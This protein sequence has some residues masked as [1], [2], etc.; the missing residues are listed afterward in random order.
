MNKIC[1]I[2]LLTFIVMMFSTVALAQDNPYAEISTSR[3]DDGAFVLGNPEAPVKLIEFS[4]FLCPHCQDY[5]ATIDYFIENYVAT[6]QAQFEYRMYPIV[7]ANL[8]P[9]TAVL[10]ECADEQSEGLFWHAHDVMFELTTGQQFTPDSVDAF[11]EALNLDREAL[12]E[13]ALNANQF[14][15]DTEYGNLLNINGTPTVAVQ[16]ADSS[17][18]LVALPGEAEFERL[19][20][21]NRPID[22]EPVM[23]ETGRYTGIPTYRTDNGGFV[24]GD[25]DAPLTIV[26]FEDFMCPHCQSYQPTLHTFIEDYVAT[27]QAKFE[28]RF[29][30][31]VDPEFSMLTAQVAECVA[32]QDLSKFWDAHDLLF[33]FAATSEIDSQVASV[34]AMLVGVDTDEINNCLDTSIQPLI[35]LQLGRQAQVTG[36][37][38]VRA[39]SENGQLEI[40]YAG[41]QPLQRGA[42]PLEALVALAEGSNEISIGQTLLNNALLQDDSL[43]TG[44]PCE[45]PCWQNI[46][47]GET[48]FADA[49]TTI[50]QLADTN[51]QDTDNSFVFSLNTGSACCQIASQD[52]QTVSTILLRLAPTNTLGDLIDANG[53]PS[54]VTGEPFSESEHILTLVYP[55][56]NLIIFTVVDGADGQLTND[57]PIITAVY[58][59]DAVMEGFVANS[60]I[61]NWKGFLT[62]NDYMDGEFDYNG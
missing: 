35:D 5:K 31:L 58:M 52:L 18:V 60:P 49:R 47:P 7:N 6:G 59:S 34:I 33:E 38:G 21:A 42:I 37:P 45:A 48:S 11:T 22:S 30:P 56:I 44:E 27:G 4:D 24:L 16:Y 41:Q 32:V 1:K 28:Y 8:S 54:F 40:I 29:F 39:R 25:P 46:T 36:T 55:E 9:Y 13:C 12:D 61:D 3:T 43:I 14:A 62:Y 53:E 51:I 20:N 10:V 50:E 19:I 57:T 23:V 2:L 26:A 15:T 17:P